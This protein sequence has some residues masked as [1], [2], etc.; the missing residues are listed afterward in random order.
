MREKVLGR[1]QLAFE[2]SK[3]TEL[4]ERYNFHQ[5]RH[6]AAMKRAAELLN[7]TAE[8]GINDELN[9]G[10]LNAKFFQEMRVIIKSIFG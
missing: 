1:E 8:F 3:E 9:C 7:P 4:N 5:I 2:L 6:A 10:K